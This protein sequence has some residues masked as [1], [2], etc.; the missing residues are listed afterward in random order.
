MISCT[1]VAESLHQNITAYRSGLRMPAALFSEFN[2][3]GLYDHRDVNGNKVSQI[4]ILYDIEI[5]AM[6]P[7]PSN[8][9]FKIYNIVNEFSL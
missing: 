9:V 5:T 6:F 4:T 3:T 7:N 8:T 1:P 2:D